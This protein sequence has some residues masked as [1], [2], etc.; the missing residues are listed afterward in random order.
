MRAGAIRFFSNLAI[1]FSF[2]KFNPA[3]SSENT[4]NAGHMCTNYR[5]TQTSG[6]TI[7]P[8]FLLD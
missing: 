8:C 1:F 3:E 7:G 4:K 2:L 5:L 6:N